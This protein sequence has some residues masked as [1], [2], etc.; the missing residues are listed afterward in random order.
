MTIWTQHAM[1]AAAPAPGRQALRLACCVKAGID[2][3]RGHG[4]ENPPFSGKTRTTRR[5]RGRIRT[6]PSKPEEFPGWP[7]QCVRDS[8]DGRQRGVANSALQAADV[9]PIKS[10]QFR[11]GFLG[12]A[13]ADSFGSDGPRQHEGQ[14]RGGHGATLWRCG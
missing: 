1:I 6:Q 7:S 12:E 8:F 4:P 9:G 14:I 13:L 5:D 2:R 3:R 11:K 10:G